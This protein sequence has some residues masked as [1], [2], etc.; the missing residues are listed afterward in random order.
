MRV[1]RHLLDGGIALPGIAQQFRDGALA[2][3]QHAVVILVDGN[4][5]SEP[6]APKKVLAVQQ[7]QIFRTTEKTIAGHL[8][9][10]GGTELT[11]SH[12]GQSLDIP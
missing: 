10:T 2:I 3:K 9:E 12:P 5:Q 8:I 1:P 7:L 11:T 4:V 6:Q